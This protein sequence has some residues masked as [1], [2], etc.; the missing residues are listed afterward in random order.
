MHAPCRTVVYLVGWKRG[1][2]L[3]E[4]SIQMKERKRDQKKK[5]KGGGEG[6]I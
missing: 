3:I 5:K 2:M 4:D 1:G 6:L